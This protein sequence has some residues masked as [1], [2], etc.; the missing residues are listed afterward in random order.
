MNRVARL[1]HEPHPGDHWIEP[2]MPD[3]LTRLREA[4][5]HS[6]IDEELKGDFAVAGRLADEML[7]KAY[8]RESFGGEAL[9][10]RGTRGSTDSPATRRRG[11][12]HHLPW[13][14]E[15]PGGTS[16][17]ERQAVRSRCS[18]PDDPTAEPKEN[19]TC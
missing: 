4:L 11:P 7:E 3:F 19:S 2:V 12:S 6:I 15:T 13:C 5:G 8:L 9:K 18:P 17:Y 14:R 10:H 16:A 1:S